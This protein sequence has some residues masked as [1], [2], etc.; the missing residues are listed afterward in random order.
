MKL[1]FLDIDG[2]LNS[3]S[4]QMEFG[5]HYLNDIPAKKHVKELDRIVQATGAHIVISSTWRRSVDCHVMGMLL[6]AQGLT[7]DSCGVVQGS[8]PILYV[9]DNPHKAEVIRGIEIK[10]YMDHLND[11]ITRPFKTYKKLVTI[12]NYVILDDDSDMLP[13]QMKHFV[14]TNSKEGLTPEKA[15]EAIRILNG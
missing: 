13:E 15:D 1:I 12:D 4:S 7:L 5:R 9:E 14:Q 6:Y 10:Y 11:D 3:E 2:V 8:T